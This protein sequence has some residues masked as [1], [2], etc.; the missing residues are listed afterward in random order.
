MI[1]AYPPPEAND[2][3][4]EEIAIVLQLSGLSRVPKN[5]W[6][7]ILTLTH[8]DNGVLF[9]DSTIVELHWGP[10]FG[11]DEQ[12]NEQVYDEV[13]ERHTR[14]VCWDYYDRLEVFEPIVFKHRHPKV[15][16]AAKK[17]LLKKFKRRAKTFTYT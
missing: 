8:V 13:R 1:K 6:P 9:P 5:R 16:E 3:S 10:S 17:K 14:R 11:Q 2:L 15:V 7:P 4:E 12:G